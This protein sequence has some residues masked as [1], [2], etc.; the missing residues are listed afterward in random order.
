AALNLLGAALAS[1]GDFAGARAAYEK[2]IAIDKSFETPQLNL[3]KLDAAERK[4]DQARQRLSALLASRA[5][6][7]AARYELAMLDQRQQRTDDARRRLEELHEKDRSHLAGHLAL[8]DLYLDAGALDKALALANESS[9]NRPG[10]LALQ[11]ALVR[12]QLARGDDSAARSTLA[13]MT[14]LADFNSLAQYKI[15]RLQVMAG[16]VAGARYSLEKAL[17]GDSDFK[18]AKVALAD[19]DLAEGAIGKVE[20]RLAELLKSSPVPA[21]AYR[22]AGDLAATKAQ[23]QPAIGY[24]RSALAN[25]MGAD[26]ASRLYRAYTAAGQRKQG[27][28]AVEALVKE[29]QDDRALRL[30][31]SDAQAAEG[32]LREAKATLEFLLKSGDTAFLL[33]NL[34]FA[35]RR[36]R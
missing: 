5:S 3:A 35:G 8:I 26:V 18:P 24:Y 32:Q 21:E 34:L 25:G 28:A 15:S 16:N 20:S 4:L 30:L 1:A 23:W 7:S 19:L 22:L 9:P 12:V 17:Q 10:Y 31:L 29:R 36:S 27:L 11:A 13:S 2:A 33:N 6:G 14:R